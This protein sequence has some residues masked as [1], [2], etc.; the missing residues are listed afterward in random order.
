MKLVITAVEYDLLN[1]RFQ[2][3][4]SDGLAYGCCGGLVAAI[5]QILPKNLITATD[6]NQGLTLGV[7]DNLG[8]N[9]LVAAKNRQ[10]RPG[11]VTLQAVADADRPPLTLSQYLSLMLHD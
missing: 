5:T 2:S 9:V 11:S 8:V 1:A 7:I 4:L 10:T 6:R 3:P